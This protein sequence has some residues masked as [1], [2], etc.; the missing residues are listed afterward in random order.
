MPSAFFGDEIRSSS[1]VDALRRQLI[2]TL[3]YGELC[4]I[5]LSG[6]SLAF[7]TCSV[8]GQIDGNEVAAL[9]TDRRGSAKV[10]YLI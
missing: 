4:M 1:M 6:S 7:G 10:R 2:Y 3:A 8:V 5:T 9:I